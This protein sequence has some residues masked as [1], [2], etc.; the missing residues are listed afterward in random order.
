MA[1]YIKGLMFI[2]RFFRDYSIFKTYHTK[3]KRGECILGLGRKCQVFRVPECLKR[4]SAHTNGFAYKEVH[5]NEKSGL[6]KFLQ[7]VGDI[8]LIIKMDVE[9]YIKMDV[10]R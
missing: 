4:T 8:I 3:T 1:K 7:K 5:K 6:L 2:S 10:E 9:R